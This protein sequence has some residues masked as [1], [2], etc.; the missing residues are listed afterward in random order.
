MMQESALLLI[1][2]VIKAHGIKGQL[3]ALFYTS[4][5]LKTTWVYLKPKG[6]CMQLY[7]IAFIRPLKGHYIVGLEGIRSLEQAKS[8][9]GASVYCK[10]TDLP[11]L[12][13]EEY[14]WY[15]VIGLEVYLES[16]KYLGKVAHIFNK[17][18]NDVFVVKSKNEEYL[19]PATFEVIKAFDWERGVLWI[20]PIEGLL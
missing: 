17:G 4:T 3:K 5:F 9:I 11:P 18:S 6:G 16:G 15:Q 14:Y 10:K 19:I 1:G 12:D 8:L 7:R 13:K 2:E 20:N